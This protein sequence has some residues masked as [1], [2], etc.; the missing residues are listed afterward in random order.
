[1]GEFRAFCAELDRWDIAA[2]AAAPVAAPVAAP[3]VVV[4]GGGGPAACGAEVAADSATA[5]R[6]GETSVGPVAADKNIAFN[7]IC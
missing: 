4:G 7:L 1:M 6:E 2:P 3:I 5:A